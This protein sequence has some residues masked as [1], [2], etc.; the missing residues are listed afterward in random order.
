MSKLYHINSAY[1]LVQSLYGID[2]DV[3]NFEDLAMTAWELIGNRHT[4][5]YRFVGD[6]VNRELELP[7]NLDV[8]ESVHIPINDAQVTSNKIPYNNVDSV[9]IEGYI[10]A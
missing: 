3:D 7:C 6:T 10:D 5:L 2:A 4:R 9:F 1:P 8:I